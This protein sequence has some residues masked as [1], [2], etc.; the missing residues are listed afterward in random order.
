MSLKSKIEALRDQ[1]RDH[2]YRYYVLNQPTISDFDFDQMFR[3]L[4]ELE[5]DHPE[6]I[7]PDS[8]T[9]RV[10]GI[11]TGAFPTHN[12]SQPMLS[13]DNAYS[14]EELREWHG[15]VL[16]LAGMDSVNYT[17]ELK[18]DGLSIAL[19]YEDGILIKGVTRGDGRTGEVVTANVRTIKSIPLRLRQKAS[20]EVRGEVFLSLKAFRQSNEER[21]QAGQPRFANPRNAAAGSLRQLDPTIVSRRSLDFFGYS[22]IPSRARQSENL[23]WIAELGLKVNPHHKL[24]RS[25]E[26][27]EKFYAEW[28]ERRDSLDYEIDGLVVKVDDVSLQQ[29]LGSTSKAPRWAIAVKFRPRQ[30]ETKLLDIDV[31][32]GRTG[33]L[34]SQGCA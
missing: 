4:E 13:L 16:Q 5:R 33:A 26:D 34:D 22:P 8:P 30:A 32:V 25:I 24:C 3:E 20:I 12:F 2:Q 6:L 27:V 10:G 17:A 31:Q 14:V 7:T 21:E 15:R 11:V 9:Q 1:I 28:E 29:K 23:K 19:L 18:I